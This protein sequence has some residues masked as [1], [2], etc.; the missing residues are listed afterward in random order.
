MGKLL[1]AALALVSR[2]IFVWPAPAYSEGIGKSLAD[3]VLMR[4]SK[5]LRKEKKNGSL[6]L[7]EAP[8]FAGLEG[9]AVRRPVVAATKADV[10]VRFLRG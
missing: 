4:D 8:L 6:M 5:V 1:P 9:E 2:W 7:G 3:A 10:V